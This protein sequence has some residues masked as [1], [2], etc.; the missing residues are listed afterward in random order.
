MSKVSQQLRGNFENNHQ[1]QVIFQRNKN[2]SLNS[3]FLQG[4]DH[5]AIAINAANDETIRKLIDLSTSEQHRVF[6]EITRQWKTISIGKSNIFS[7]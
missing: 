2:M 1:F 6:T 5:L 3:T 4:W 7:Y